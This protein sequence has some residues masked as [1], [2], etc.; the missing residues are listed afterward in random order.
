M[1]GGIHPPGEPAHYRDASIRELVGEFFCAI[2]RVVRGL[3]CADDSNGMAVALENIA[4]HVKNR[5]RIMNVAE[6]G[7]I[8]Q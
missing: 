7:G 4:N 3:A 5:R 1:R 6:Q 8:I 2:R